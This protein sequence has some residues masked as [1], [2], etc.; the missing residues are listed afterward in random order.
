[1]FTLIRRVGPLA[2]QVL[3]PA[4]TQEDG[5]TG[6]IVGFRRACAQRLGGLGGAGSTATHPK[7]L[8]V[9]PSSCCFDGL[10]RRGLAAHGVQGQ[11]D[12]VQAFGQ[13]GVV[14]VFA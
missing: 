1:M 4:R 3:G 6:R 12:S 13:V 7:N 5:K 11:V 14:A 9:F 8:P 10:G 2:S